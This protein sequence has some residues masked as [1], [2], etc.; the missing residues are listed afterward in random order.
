MDI[1]TTTTTTYRRLRTYGQMER[2]RICSLPQYRHRLFLSRTGRILL[3][4]DA[5]RIPIHASGKNFKQIVVGFSSGGGGVAGH[6]SMRSTASSTSSSSSS[7]GGGVAGHSSM[8]STAS[9]S[10]S[11]SPS[12]GSISELLFDSRHGIRLSMIVVIFRNLK[13]RIRRFG[14]MTDA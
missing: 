9:T 2:I 8:R 6:S 13:Y 4:F 10:T 7:G 1:F 11:S 14:S 12:G 3:Y 5:G